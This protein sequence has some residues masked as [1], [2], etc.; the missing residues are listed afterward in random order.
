MISS[1][2]L[3][4]LT[5]YLAFL[6]L[7][8]AALVL[9]YFQPKLDESKSLEQKIAVVAQ[10]TAQYERR[11]AQNLAVRQ[12]FLE[13]DHFYIDKQL[14]TVQLLE[15]EIEQLQQVQRASHLAENEAIQ[16]RLEH[17]VG[18]GNKIAFTEGVVQ[19]YPY[20]KETTETLIHP[21]EI[22]S[23]D[24]MHILAIIEGHQVGPYE[25]MPGRPQLL[26]LDFKLDKKNSTPNNQVFLLNLKLLKRE[27]T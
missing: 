8:P 22:D 10:R 25:P 18:K 21:V 19:S 3:A 6:A 17:L 13:A 15:R 2:P 16:K 11:Q 27:F 20:F 7:I 12:H 26:I 23:T 9:L 24:L 1:I 4:R 5:L 14:E